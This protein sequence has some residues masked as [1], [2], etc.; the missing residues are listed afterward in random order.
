MIGDVGKSTVFE[1]IGPV[2]V[3]PSSSHTA[4]AVRLGLLARK[5]LGKAPEAGKIILHG[6]FA[7]TGK[8]HG[9]H[10][11]LVAGLLGMP[12]DDERIC[13]ALNIAREKGFN[14]AFS[15][16]N[17][18][19][20]HPNT[21][22]FELEKGKGETVV[23]TGS[24]IGG[25]RVKVWDINGFKVDLEGDYP[26]IVTLHRDLPGVIAQVTGCLAKAHINIA[27]MQV[28]R[29]KRGAEAMMVVKTD[30]AVTLE[31]IEMLGKLEN[32]I[33][34]MFIEPLE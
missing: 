31:T 28:A 21:V 20:V 26:T 6:S 10:V 9:T 19:D 1:L 11:A 2:M 32:M 29:E 23:V 12:T 4:G 25:G 34:V 15:E 18:G 3:G 30:H 22:R 13:D 8:G 27:Y 33:R 24:S 5:V 16:G 17:L 7:E 14:Y